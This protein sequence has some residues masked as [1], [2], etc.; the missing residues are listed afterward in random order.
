M[1]IEVEAEAADKKATGRDSDKD[2]VPLEQ[3]MQELYTEKANA[4]FDIFLD[5]L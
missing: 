5:Y 3:L 2:D 4:T 1:R